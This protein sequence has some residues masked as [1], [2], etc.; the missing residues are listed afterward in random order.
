MMTGLT[1]PSPA[2]IPSR[3][4]R[5]KHVTLQRHGRMK[6]MTTRFVRVLFVLVFTCMLGPSAYAGGW[7]QP[8]GDFYLKVWDR[9]LVGKN[10]FTAGGDTAELPDTFQDHQL[11][12][13][14]EYGLLDELTLTLSVVPVGFASYE[15]ESRAYFGGATAG[16]R[17]RFLTG[18]LVLAVSAHAGGRPSSGDPLGVAVV[19]NET[20]VVDPVVGTIYG[21]AALE[22]GYGLSFGWLAAS[23]G[24][25]AFSRKELDP[26]LFA[27]LQ[28]GWN[29][30]I[31]LILDVHA[32][33]YHAFGELAPVNVLGAGQT[34]YL[35]FGLGLSWWFHDHVGVN[36][37]FGGAFFA[38]SNA[39][40]PAITLGLEF[41]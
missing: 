34:R 7:T 8:E 2:P 10:A 24:T 41:R 15:G 3:D 25:R 26:A 21:G 9:T 35:G 20:Y 27:N 23:F 40:T 1:P 33:W 12:I 29:T 31:G 17:Y 38:R 14:G 6:A 30:G 13:Y 4:F 37:G 28:F 36:A 16:A 39:A 5:S 19:G 18:P 22:A 11:N 32:G